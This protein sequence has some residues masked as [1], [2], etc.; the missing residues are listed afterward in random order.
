MVSILMYFIFLVAWLIIGGDVFYLWRVLLGAPDRILRGIEVGE[1][2]FI[3]S[4]E[5]K[6]FRFS[7]SFKNAEHDS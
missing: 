7:N 5:E 3:R 2:S 6:T 4:K 1:A